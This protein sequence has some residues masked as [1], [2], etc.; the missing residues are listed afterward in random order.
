MQGIKEK[1][2]FDV[3]IN[4]GIYMLDPEIISTLIREIQITTIFSSLLAQTNLCIASLV[5]SWADVGHHD[6]F[7]STI[8]FCAINDDGCFEI[9]SVYPSQGW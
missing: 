9:F 8:A 7:N 5:E 3:M 4:A 1:W 2:T 6:D